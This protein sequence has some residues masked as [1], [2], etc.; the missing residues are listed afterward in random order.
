MCFHEKSGVLVTERLEQRPGLADLVEHIKRNWMGMGCPEDVTYPLT[1]T[2]ARMLAAATV[3][4][5]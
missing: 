2:R 4:L 1:Q 3:A 5:R